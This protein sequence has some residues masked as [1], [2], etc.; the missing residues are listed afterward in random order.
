[1]IILNQPAGTAIEQNSDDI[2]LSFNQWA[3]SFIPH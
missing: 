3:F 1:M 2:K